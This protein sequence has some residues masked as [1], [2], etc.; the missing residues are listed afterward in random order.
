MLVFA[1]MSLPDVLFVCLFVFEEEKAL[2]VIY[3][4]PFQYAWNK[5][6]NCRH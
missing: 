1:A 6:C 2:C 3:E 4:I 5:S